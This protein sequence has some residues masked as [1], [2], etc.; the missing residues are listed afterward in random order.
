MRHGEAH[1]CTEGRGR[2][3]GF[4]Q[5]RG[6]QLLMMTVMSL[7]V[8]GE[9]VAKPSLRGSSSS[10]DRQN[11]AANSASLKRHRTPSE[12]MRSVRGGKL[13]KVRGEGLFEL[14]NVSY[15]YAQPQLR[16]FLRRFARTF[17]RECGETLVVT[18]LSRPISTQPR[19]A[20]PRSVHP[21]G[22]AADLRLPPRYCRKKI[23][24]ILLALEAEGVIEATR[25]RRPP[26]YH[27]A[28]N[29]RGFK[30]AL[31][32]GRGALSALKRQN[33]KVKRRPKARKRAAR[34]HKVYR[35]RS[36]DTLWDLARRWR[37]SVRE[38]KRMNG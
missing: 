23:E 15:P 5:R 22:I 19:N 2:P 26:H 38:I 4:D 6:V 34:A 8:S 10:M 18:S 9:V 24:P 13:V 14:H 28:I 35:V 30:R 16:D 33:V 20:S 17:R 32:R 27:L 37:T 7:L 29:P 31:R 25:E 11:R 3:S 21:T 36:G 1:T 12:L